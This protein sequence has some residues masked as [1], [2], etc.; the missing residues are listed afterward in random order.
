M[1]G[2][3]V[4]CLHV[5]GWPSLGVSCFW[6]CAAQGP[7]DL[8]PLEV[9]AFNPSDLGSVGNGLSVPNPKDYLKLPTAAELAQVR[10]HPVART[11]MLVLL[12]W[13]STLCCVGRAVN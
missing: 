8:P 9:P 6:I 12:P 11:R 4:T 1:C 5:S 3:I 10:T 7:V 13:H 2:T